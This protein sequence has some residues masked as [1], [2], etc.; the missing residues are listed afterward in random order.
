MSQPA[1]PVADAIPNA[2]AQVKDEQR[3]VDLNA[4]PPGALLRRPRL[5]LEFDFDVALRHWQGLSNEE[6]QARFLGGDPVAQVAAAFEAEMHALT[7]ARG[8]ALAR[9]R[10]QRQLGAELAADAQAA[11][12]EQAQAA[13]DARRQSNYMNNDHK[14]SVQK[15]PIR[16][17]VTDLQIAP[18]TAVH[19]LTRM[20]LAFGAESLPWPVSRNDMNPLTWASGN[21]DELR[22][23][24]IK[25]YAFMPDRPAP[26]DDALWAWRLVD[27]VGFDSEGKIAAVRPPSVCS[28]MGKFGGKWKGV[29]T[30]GV[31]ILEQTP[32]LYALAKGYDHNTRRANRLAEQA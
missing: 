16:I 13:K 18:G 20:Y 30:V 15:N 3:A 12:D 17:A 31:P 24:G 21:L 1:N 10:F 25:F 28:V 26:H 22:A 5:E 32:V 6:K 8:I 7:M 19:L 11:D 4:V 29:K 14:L 27:V 2:P 23:A 9:Q